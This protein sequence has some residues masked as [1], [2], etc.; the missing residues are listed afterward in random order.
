MEAGGLAVGLVALASL[1]NNA[2]D[3]FE[4]VQLGRSFGTNFQTSLL[5]LDNARLRLSRWGQAVGLSGNLE[6]VQSLQEATVQKE[7][8]AKA[9]RLLGQIMELFADTEKISTKYK[10]SVKL[11]DSSL[12]I[13]N[14]RKLSIKR[15]NGTKLL[16]KVKWALYEEKHFKRL[17]EDIIN[18]VGDLL[19]VF[20]AV[21]QEQLKLCEMEVSEI[22]VECLSVLID[23]VRS[24][25]KDLEA[26]ISAA[27]KSD[28]KQGT[29]FNNYN[30]KVANQAANIAI[31]GGQTIH[32]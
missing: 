24:Q 18:L 10:R 17:I 12:T 15:Q 25:D 31:H 19:E 5:K 20:L 16:Q 26:A 1:F 4:Y 8:I 7:D 3:C 2:V 21:K 32:L 23:I 11:D 22:G 27:M 29:V 9:E 13:L 30:S 14:M 28:S 6:E